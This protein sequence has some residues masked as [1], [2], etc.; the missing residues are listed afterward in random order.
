MKSTILIILMSYCSVLFA[1]ELQEERTLIATDVYSASIDPLQQIYYINKSKQLIKTSSFQDRNYIY[2]D[3]MIDQNTSINT[4]NPFKVM[5][6][7]KDV[8]DVIVLDNRLAKNSK[9]NLFNLGYFSVSS[10]TYSMDNHSIILFDTY[11]QQIIKLDQQNKEIF[12]SVNLTQLLQKR[13]SPVQIKEYE[14]K[15]YLLDPES[16]VYVFDQLGT[17]IKNIP[18]ENVENFWIISKQIY[19]YRDQQIWLYN[20]DLFEEIP[21]YRLEDYTNIFLC[22]DFILGITPQNELYQINWK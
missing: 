19:Y 11:R 21:Q 7:K 18:I 1:K 16:G 14:N 13:I 5:L 22:R 9:M 4:Q 8:G 17:Y 10:I 15:L 6:Y 3:L 20:S 2:S 12:Q